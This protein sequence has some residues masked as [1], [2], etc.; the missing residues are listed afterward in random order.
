M[1]DMVD[2]LLALW[3][4]TPAD[5]EAAVAAFRELYTDPVRINGEPMTAAELVARARTLIAA[6]EGLRREVIDEFEAPGRVVV[7]YRLTGRHVGPVPTPLGE[8]AATGRPIEGL[9][10]D[11]LFI[12]DDRITDVWATSDDLARL[13]KLDVLRLVQPGAR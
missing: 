9:T 6:F 5:D 4:D 7:V 13:T 8:L 11:V 10:I 2:R 12:A 3:T 1:S